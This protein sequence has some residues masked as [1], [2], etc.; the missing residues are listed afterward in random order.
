MWLVDLFRRQPAAAPA[1]AAPTT[2]TTDDEIETLRATLPRL[3]GSD[4]EFAQDLINS[5]REHGHL[6]ERQQPWVGKLIERANSREQIGDYN[7]LLALFACAIARRRRGSTIILQC[8]GMAGIRLRGEGNTG[9]DVYEHHRAKGESAW[10][11]SIRPDGTFEATWRRE[12]PAAVISTLRAFAAD[13][14]G[15][16]AAH[17][18]A[19]GRCCFC[20]KPLKTERSKQLGYGP[21]CGS[22]NGLPH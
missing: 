4:R 12:V 17:R 2:P 7:G 16:A 22:S 19:T 20:D 1:P 3:F 21:E 18:H 9:I 10:L 11:G 5:F 6:T 14:A 13:P 15:Q 8:D